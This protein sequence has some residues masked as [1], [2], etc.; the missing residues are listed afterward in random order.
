M[1]AFGESMPPAA[2]APGYPGSYGEAAM[3]NSHSYGSSQLPAAASLQLYGPLEV[4][5]SA[6]Q[7]A[8]GIA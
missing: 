3:H 7:C 8:W 4:S 1:Q 6:Q 2:H 5:I